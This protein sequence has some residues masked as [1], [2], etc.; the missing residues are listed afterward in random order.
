MEKASRPHRITSAD[1]A[2]ACGVSRAT[3]SYVLNNDPRQT[4][5]LETRE[6]VLQAARE[7]GYSPFAPARLLRSGRSQ[8]V[9]AVLPFEQVDPA[10]SRSL[11][12]LEQRLALHDLTLLSYVGVHPQMGTMHPSAHITPSVLLSY[13]DQ[14]DPL[15]ADFLQP[16]HAPILH[17]LGDARIEEQV[18]NMQA[19]YLI[20]S[21]KRSLLF[22]ASERK[23]VQ[24]LS[25]YRFLGV[26][27]ACLQGECVEP[28]LCVL[29]SSRE[30]ARAVLQDTLTKSP[31][32]WGICCYNDEV[33]FAALAALADENIAVP[34]TAAVVGC[35]NIPLAQWSLPAL[36]TIAFHNEP[37]LDSLI[38]A[39]V[40]LSRGESVSWKA[41]KTLTLITR[42]SA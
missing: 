16:F 17:L 23:D 38:E 27:Q 7:L 15:V 21:G 2:R 32:P 41:Q 8:L 4:I 42:A 14:T 19:Q 39:I 3:V 12:E 25:H 24:R 28:V 6:R 40:A 31:S 35:D 30:E 18:G 26:Q 20:Q 37:G 11:K 10:L 34:L 1:V 13:A 5:P 33:A 36:T 22:L 9:L 29:P